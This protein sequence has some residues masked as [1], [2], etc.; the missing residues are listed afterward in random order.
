MAG[1]ATARGTAALA[2][3]VAGDAIESNAAAATI[4]VKEK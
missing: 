1:A 3:S 2:E 4:I